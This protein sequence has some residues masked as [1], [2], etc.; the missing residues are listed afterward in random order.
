ME[1]AL[2][3]WIEDQTQKKIPLSSFIIHEKAKKTVST[4]QRIWWQWWHNF[5]SQQKLVRKLKK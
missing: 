2:N 3:V 5:F 1:K 4:L